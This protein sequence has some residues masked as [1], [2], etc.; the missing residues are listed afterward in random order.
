MDGLKNDNN[1]QRSDR[2][3]MSECDSDLQTLRMYVEVQT[4]S[5][6]LCGED[7]AWGLANSTP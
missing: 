3:I 2:L 1:S 5:F 7:R 6:Y 4:N